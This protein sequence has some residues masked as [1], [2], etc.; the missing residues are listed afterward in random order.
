MFG[1]GCCQSGLDRASW[2]SFQRL[3]WPPVENWQKTFLDKYILASTDKEK[4]WAKRLFVFYVLTDLLDEG[5]KS[6]YEN[7]W[8]CR[9]SLQFAE[10]NQIIQN[11]IQVLNHHCEDHDFLLVARAA[12]LLR[13]SI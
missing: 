6:I 1:A 4:L 8:K 5:P 7:H 12:N 10:L 3:W 9:D 11:E 2:S 13:C